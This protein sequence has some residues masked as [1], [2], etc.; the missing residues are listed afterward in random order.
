MT[1]PP[2]SGTTPVIVFKLALAPV[3][4]RDGLRGAGRVERGDRN[5]AD[6]VAGDRR[7]V[8]NRVARDRGGR[9]AGG[10]GRVARAQLIGAQVQRCCE[11]VDRTEDREGEDEGEER[12]LLH[13]GLE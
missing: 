3:G 11:A 6:L 5:G 8:R 10:D 13:Q 4:H 12:L 2:A 7:V 1:P 9:L